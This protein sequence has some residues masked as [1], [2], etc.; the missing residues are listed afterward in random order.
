VADVPSGLSLT[1]QQ[2]TKK[3]A[4]ILLGCGLYIRLEE[5]GKL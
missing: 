5:W 2:K 1:P 3:S 4:L